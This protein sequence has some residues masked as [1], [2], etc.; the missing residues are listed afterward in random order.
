M[1]N[2]GHLYIRALRKATVE[3]KGS[4]DIWVS[5]SA[6]LAEQIRHSKADTNF[7]SEIG[8][9]VR[10]LSKWSR[11]LLLL[12]AMLSDKEEAAALAPLVQRDSRGR[13]FF[14]PTMS[15]L[16]VALDAT[17]SDDPH[18][19]A[20]ALNLTEVDAGVARRVGWCNTY[21]YNPGWYGQ[22]QQI[23]EADYVSLRSAAHQTDAEYVFALL[24]AGIPAN[25]VT[26]LCALPPMPLEYAIAMVG[27]AA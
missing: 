15:E 20:E 3:R 11:L 16:M 27:D 17:A 14:I 5:G 4:L 10:V 21:R 13:A 19:I 24:D 8:S 26:Q 9:P 18:A 1:V 2:A 12:P 6:Y 25:A 23:T 7:T 22:Q